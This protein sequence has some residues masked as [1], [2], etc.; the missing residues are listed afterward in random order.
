MKA[1]KDWFKLKKYPH[2]GLP[3]SVEDRRWL[4]PYIRNPINIKKHSFL[5]FIHKTSRVKKFRKTYDTHS[6]KLIRLKQKNKDAFR[7]PDEKKREL[8]YSSHIDSLIFSYYN[9]LL[10]DAY[11]KIICDPT[12]ALDE[13]V[14]AYRT[15][16]IDIKN[17]D[18]ANKC[19]IDFANDLFNFIKGFPEEEFLVVSFDIS[20][21]FDHL[22]HKKLLDRWKEILGVIKLPDDHFNIYKN[23]TR[24]SHVDIVDIFEFF[25][26][27]IYV[28]KPVN[29]KYKQK[30]ISKIRFLKN[31][32]AVA[33]CTEKEFFK[34]KNKLLQP[35]KTKRLKNG[36]VVYRNFGIP[37]G[38]A[39]SSSLANMYLLH[40]DKAINDFVNSNGI[41]R[42]Y[43][44]DIVV[45]C[46]LSN[47]CELLKLVQT[48]IEKCDLEIQESKTQIFHFKRENN[49]LKCG[50]EFINGINWNKSFINLGFQFDGDKVLIKSGSLA[51]YYRKMKRAIKRAL[52]FASQKN[53][54]HDGI[55][56]RRL[57]KRFSYKGAR[58]YRKWIWDEVKKVFYKSEIQNWGNFLSYSKKAARTISSKSIIKQTAKHWKIIS[59]LLRK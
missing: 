43:S 10:S 46:S 23:I 31:Q 7:V 34:V 24:F 3:I 44:D 8:F 27:K 18:S 59:Q 38:S 56:R 2:I 57:F 21:F 54:F 42:R 51:G 14:T 40:F 35:S 16:P 32:N 36:K 26:N 33:F 17:P 58:I 48:E 39:I 47:K 6:G 53:A 1:K 19:N 5:P 52:Y 13:V 4:E 45:V 55:F 30:S 50:Q 11:E 15:I 20:S 37:Q 28:G 12:Y 25:K 41:Y 9:Q 29:K 22:N 49:K